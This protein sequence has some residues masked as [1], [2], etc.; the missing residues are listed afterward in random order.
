MATVNCGCVELACG[1]AQLLAGYGRDT[2]AWAYCATGAK[3]RHSERML[4]FQITD[5]GFN[6]RVGN[7]EDAAQ[8]DRLIRRQRRV[9]GQL[10]R[11]LDILRQPT[12]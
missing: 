5:A 6:C 4:G 3:L 1:C 11:H 2:E 7:S 8:R 12:R 10:N 9:T